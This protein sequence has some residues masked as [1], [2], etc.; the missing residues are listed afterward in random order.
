MIGRTTRGDRR[1]AM[2]KV[3][4]DTAAEYYGLS[5]DAMRKRIKRGKADAVRESG[6]WYVFIPDSGSENNGQIAD[7]S[8]Q[9]LEVL[10]DQIEYLQQ[11][12]YRK[13][14]II[15]ELSKRVPELPAADRLPWW[16][17]IFNPGR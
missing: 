15:M 3:D 12:N 1:A 14:M 6:R 2:K 9:L 7:K 5:K 11:E 4:L 17:K 13:D 16:K 10:K 8:G